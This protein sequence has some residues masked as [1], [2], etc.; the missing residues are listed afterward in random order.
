MKEKT[1]VLSFRIKESVYK[2][3][4]EKGI[5][6][7]EYARECLENC[8]QNDVSPNDKTAVKRESC[9]QKPKPVENC[10]QKEWVNPFLREGRSEKVVSP[11]W[12]EKPTKSDTPNPMMATK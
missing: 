1:V 7:K 12:L 5:E 6:P 10:I 8:I 9:I 3:L 2:K 4:L 11:K